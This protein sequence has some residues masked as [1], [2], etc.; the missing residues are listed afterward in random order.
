VEGGYNSDD[1]GVDG[2]IIL[3]WSLGKLSS[4]VWIRLIWLRIWTC[5]GL[6]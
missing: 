6:L 4:R 3:K 2:R 5:G 1:V